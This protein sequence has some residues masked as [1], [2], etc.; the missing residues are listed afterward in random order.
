MISC[1]GGMQ[2]RQLKEQR[3]REVQLGSVGRGRGRGVDLRPAW[4]KAQDKE[5]VLP[6]AVSL[7][8]SVSIALVLLI[9]CQ[10]AFAALPGGAGCSLLRDL[11]RACFARPSEEGSVPGFNRDPDGDVESFGSAAAPPP[12]S[13]GGV[14]VGRGVDN[15]PAWMKAQDASRCVCRHCSCMSRS[16]QHGYLYRGSAVC[17]A[18]VHQV[19]CRRKCHRPLHKIQRA[20]EA[21][22]CAPPGCATATAPSPRTCCQIAVC[23]L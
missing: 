7:R 12:R 4:M 20:A 11:L 1:D 3:E 16:E 14:S 23:L 10:I 5:C 13:F 21:M 9:L 6:P 15:R 19:A 22:I 2:R 18:V 8:L 17:G